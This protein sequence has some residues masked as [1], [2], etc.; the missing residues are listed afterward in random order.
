MPHLGA[1]ALSLF[2]LA[3]GG[4]GLAY[5][6][7][8]QPMRAV[9]AEDPLFLQSASVA[10]PT[11]IWPRSSS[12]AFYTEWLQL[13]SSISANTKESGVANAAA[14]EVESNKPRKPRQNKRRQARRDTPREEAR[15]TGREEGRISFRC[16][17]ERCR[18]K[19]VVRVPFEERGSERSGY[20][21]GHRERRGLFMFQDWD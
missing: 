12:V 7:L 19:R 3:V 11:R 8:I 5:T 20:A 6:H 4:G 1:I 10:L 2:G 13:G 14:D 16:L 9:P 21:S 15:E 18:M 17:D